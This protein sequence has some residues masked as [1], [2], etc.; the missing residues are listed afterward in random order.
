VLASDGI[1]FCQEGEAIVHAGE[2]GGLA[3]LSLSVF[4]GTFQDSLPNVLCQRLVRVGGVGQLGSYPGFCDFLVSVHP[5]IYVPCALCQG[6]IGFLDSDHS[7][8]VLL[9]VLPH[10]SESCRRSF[11]DCF[12]CRAMVRSQAAGLASS[13]ACSVMVIPSA[14]CNRSLGAS[15][16][17]MLKSEDVI[18]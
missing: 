2:L 7:L 8:I 3:Y 18:L 14:I 15:S 10:S 17:S 12:C 16:L 5:V 13:K 11:S 1:G 6:F 4:V 9:I